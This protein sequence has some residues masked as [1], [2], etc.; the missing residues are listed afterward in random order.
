MKRYSL[1]EWLID[2][3][4]QM[5]EF[6]RLTRLFESYPEDGPTIRQV[7]ALGKDKAAVKRFLTWAVIQDLLPRAISAAWNRRIRSMRRRS[8]RRLVASLPNISTS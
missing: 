6:E 2:L 3:P 8:S 1:E 7:E 4:G 5:A